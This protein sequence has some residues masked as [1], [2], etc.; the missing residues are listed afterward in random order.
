[1]CVWF[2]VIRYRNELMH[3]S[4]FHMKDEWMKHY[5]VALR[6]LVRQFSHVPQMA[7]AGRQIEEV[8]HVRCLETL[9]S[10]R[11]I[12]VVLHHG[13]C[14]CAFC[15]S[16]CWLLICQYVSLV[17]TG[18]ILL[19]WMDLRLILSA[20]GR[21]APTWSANG[22]LSCCKRGCRSYCMLLMKQQHGCEEQIQMSMRSS[23]T[24]AHNINEDATRLHLTLSPL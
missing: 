3:S 1:M 15:L 23:G 8:K 22:R 18:W 4:E 19:I 14:A 6:N 24:F 2:Q 13:L 10:P 16:R 9:R 17:W 5:R 7:T 20:N 21:P 12:R 11:C